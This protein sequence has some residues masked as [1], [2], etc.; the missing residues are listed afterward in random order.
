MNPSNNSPLSIWQ[1]V[2]RSA[3]REPFTGDRR[4]RLRLVMNNLVLHLHPSQVPA[5]TLRFT[6]SFGLGGLAG[7]LV[8]I[9]AATGMLLETAYTP[10]PDKAYTSILALSTRIWFGQ[11]IRNL[12]HWSGNLMIIVVALHLLRVFFT[13]A[14]RAP[15]EFN[16]LVGIALL[17]LTVMANFTGYLLPWDQLAYWAITVGSSIIVYVPFIGNGLSNVLLG[18][19]E[20]GAATL[21]NFYALHISIIPMAMLALMS[22][23]FWRVRK[24]GGLSLPRGVDEPPVSK[25]ENVLTVADLVRPEAVWAMVALATLVVWAALVNAPLEALANPDASPNPAKAAWYFMGIQELLLHF[26][27]LVGAIII[28][29]LGLLG[30]GAL[31]YMD[32]DMNSVGIY[33]R[34]RRGRWLA[35][36]SAATG[37]L[38][39]AL[40]IVLD[41]YVIDFAGWFYGLP[42]LVSNGILPL[43]LLILG[44]I[45]YYEFV[46]RAFRATKC[47]GVLSVFVLVL[48]GFIVLTL[49]GVFFRGAGMQ[50]MFPWEITPTH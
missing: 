26:H 48:A 22:L 14:F 8:V 16:W 39:T 19:P 24:D 18:G 37:V 49:V 21:L 7:L 17:L 40:Y 30:L 28:P 15:R 44:I 31:P 42:A 50:L 38:L 3:V 35:L 4:S 5:R 23:H 45:G 34:S 36:F 41:E 46:R 9:L 12:H 11:F 47:E 33:F 32:S 1:R 29:T 6:Y 43:I 25:D 10:S 13:G 20:I 2:W 27:P